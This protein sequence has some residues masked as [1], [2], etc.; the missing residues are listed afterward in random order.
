[1]D[2]SEQV[3]SNLVAQY[4]QE[5]ASHLTAVIVWATGGDLSK[6]VAMAE[7]VLRR[8]DAQAQYAEMVAI[9]LAWLD[10]E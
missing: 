1:M 3:Y 6:S 7:L 2:V 9:Q 10:E 4:P 5:T 8:G